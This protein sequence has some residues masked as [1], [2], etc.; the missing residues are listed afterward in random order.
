MELILGSEGTTPDASRGPG[1]GARERL[2]RGP[3][4]LLTPASRPPTSSVR[5]SNSSNSDPGS[6]S[7]RGPRVVCDLRT[8]G[9]VWQ[10]S[11]PCQGHNRRLRVCEVCATLD[12]HRGPPPHRGAAVYDAI[13]ARRGPG[14]AVRATTT[15]TQDPPATATSAPAS[16]ATEA[17]TAFVLRTLC[18]AA[19][20]S[21]L[22][23]GRRA[24]SICGML[25]QQ[26]ARVRHIL[27]RPRK[28]P[29]PLPPPFP[30]LPPATG[31]PHRKRSQYGLRTMAGPTP[32][33]RCNRLALL[34]DAHLD[35]ERPGPRL[36]MHKQGTARLFVA[37]PQDAPRCAC[38]G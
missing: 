31:N 10:C 5:S 12:Q 26:A 22:S 37:T 18:R 7:N 16:R 23:R 36:D 33:R 1:R 27:Y 2:W 17:T 35:P 15:S 4:C 29:P 34:L 20:M 19:V 6:H 3:T 28:R 24:Q 25:S 21:W 8:R 9:F 32:R 14:T 11:P 38:L 13:C 30:I